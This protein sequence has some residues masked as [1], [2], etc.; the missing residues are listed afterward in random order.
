MRIGLY[1]ITYLGLWYRGEPLT[2]EQLIRRAREFGYDGIEIDGKRPHGNP[3]D[4]TPAR[5]RDL[6]RLADGEGIEI[7]AVAGNNDF[8]SPVPEQREA[9]IAYVR[10][11]IRLTS[12]L[13]AKLLRVFAAW[14]GITKQ[15]GI[16]RYDIARALWQSAHEKFADEETW[17]WCREGFADCARYAADAGVTLALQNH[18]PVINT[19]AD[20]L[21]MIGEVA[22]PAFRACLDAPLVAKYEKIPMRDAVLATGVLQVLSHFGGE[23][24]TAADGSARSFVRTATGLEP[25]RFYSNFVRALLDIGYD[26]YIG[27]ELCHPL[28]VASGEMAGI[29]FVDRNA[30]LAAE[31]MRQ[32]VD[33]AQRGVESEASAAS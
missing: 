19:H 3:L 27:Y 11:L 32:A 2:L 9:Q 14:P 5:A 18:P 20:M 24:D 21:C 6:R 16:G 25:E 15:D 31:Y 30:R 12:D 4:F 1:S 22:S 17:D 29:D 8:S 13:G 7:Y 23:Y 33:A 10:D 26:G 28:P